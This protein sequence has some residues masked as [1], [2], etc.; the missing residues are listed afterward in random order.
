MFAF[1]YNTKYALH[2]DVAWLYD[3]YGLLVQLMIQIINKYIKLNILENN[4]TNFDHFSLSVFEWIH[5]TVECVNIS[6]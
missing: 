4:L 5:F 6:A 2:F 1:K 3:F